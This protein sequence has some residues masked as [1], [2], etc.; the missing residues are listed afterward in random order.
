MN[1]FLLVI[2]FKEIQINA[3]FIQLMINTVHS[4]YYE[5]LY[6]EQ[7]FPFFGFEFHRNNVKKLRL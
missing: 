7:L 1:Y 2:K 4:R 6:N 3:L 5:P